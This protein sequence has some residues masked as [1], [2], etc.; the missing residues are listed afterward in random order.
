M[1]TS[2]STMCL[3]IG[4][5]ASFSSYAADDQVSCKRFVDTMQ[6]RADTIFHDTAMGFS[7]KQS[8]LS[9]LFEEGVDIAWVAQYVAGSNWNTASEKERADFVKAY[10]AYLSNRYI[11]ALDE[12][13]ISGFKDF[14]LVDFTSSPPNAYQAHIEITQK[15]DQ[16]VS[17][18]LRMELE[19]KSGC[20]VH[21]FTLEGVSL[22]QNQSEQIQSLAANGGLIN[23]T[24]KLMELVHR[25]HET[26]Q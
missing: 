19:S 7:Q 12:D 5:G 4:M 3:L 18:D 2:L 17:V 25:S 6:S 8:A 24:Q 1:R 11:G 9:G 16:P 15:A 23:V 22:L 26:S 14:T 13:D 10:R 20:R 21:D